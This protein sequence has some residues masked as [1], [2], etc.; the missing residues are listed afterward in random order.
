MV[1]VTLRRASEKE[2]DKKRT[3]VKQ[4]QRQGYRIGNEAEDAPEQRNANTK[5]RRATSND[6]YGDANRNDNGLTVPL[7]TQPKNECEDESKCRKRHECRP[8]DD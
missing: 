8:Q 2:A 7:W 3:K 5:K 1:D 4:R 6:C